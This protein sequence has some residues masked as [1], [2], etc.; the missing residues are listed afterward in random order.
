MAHPKDQDAGAGLHSPIL[1]A[2]RAMVKPLP[3]NLGAI[4]PLVI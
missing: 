1:G 3:G 4:Y 2:L